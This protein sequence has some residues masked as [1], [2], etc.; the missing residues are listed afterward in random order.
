MVPGLVRCM[1][2]LPMRMRCL[3]VALSLAAFGNLSLCAQGV[4][5]DS[6]SREPNRPGPPAGA[7]PVDYRVLHSQAQR[8]P[9]RIGG[10]D[11]ERPLS[12]QDRQEIR[13]E[14]EYV[15]IFGRPSSGI[16]WNAFRILVVEL[17]TTYKHNR[18]ESAEE[19][20]G[21]FQDADGIYVGLTFTQYGPCEGIAQ[22][23][24]WFSYAGTDLFILLPATPVRIE[25]YYRIIG[26]C[27]PDIP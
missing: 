22:Q 7:R 9:L 15:R 14:A 13:E 18:L 17:T 8:L 20:S 6:V 3:L 16:D 1:L 10:T 23:A 2:P 11:L 19:L 24:E 26:G 12:V 25:H 27:P 5:G 21:I 4:E